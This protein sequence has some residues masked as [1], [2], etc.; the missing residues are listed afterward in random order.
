MIVT[1][2][3]SIGQPIV[4]LTR[5]NLKISQRVAKIN[6]KFSFM[7]YAMENKTPSEV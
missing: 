4:S 5:E 1:D 2:P 7:P 6:D 3:Q